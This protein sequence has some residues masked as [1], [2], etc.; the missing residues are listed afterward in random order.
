M[1]KKIYNFRIQKGN[2]KSFRIERK[3]NNKNYNNNKNRYE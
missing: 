1:R 3:K 2:N